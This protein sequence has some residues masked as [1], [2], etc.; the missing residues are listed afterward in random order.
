MHVVVHHLI[1]RDD[2]ADSSDFADPGTAAEFGE[3]DLYIDTEGNDL[4]IRRT[5]RRF[6]R[7][8]AEL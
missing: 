7:M 3:R 5:R 2:T 6:S 4:E 1:S 8:G